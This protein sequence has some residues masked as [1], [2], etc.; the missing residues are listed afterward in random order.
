MRDFDCGY[1]KI[2]I[3]KEYKSHAMNA[4]LTNHLT[5]RKTKFLEDNSLELIISV[6]NKHKFENAFKENSVEATFQKPQGALS[7]I[8]RYKNRW[9]VLCGIILL[10]SSLIISSFFVWRIEVEGNELITD[11]EVIKILEESG[12]ALGTFIPNIDYDELH[13]R[14]LLNSKDV[15]WISVNITGNV[16]KVSIRERLKGNENASKNTYTNVISKYDAQIISVQLYKG[17]KVVSIG[18]VVRKGE[19]LISGVIDSQSQSVR[20]LHA[21]GIIKGYVNK[22]ILV[23]VPFK[24][25][26]KH[27]TGRVYEEKSV[28]IFSKII[29]FSIKGRNYSEFCDKIEQ[30]EAI[31]LFGVNLPLKINKTYYREYDFK[32]VNYTHSEAVDIAFKEL[33]AKLD[34]ELENS[35]IISKDVKTYYD[36]EFFYINCNLYCIEDISELVE[37]EVKN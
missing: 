14:F 23:K 32:D 12:F 37:F 31:K 8:S 18:D 3:P 20:Y 34:S 10:F 35:E 7:R 25:T 21:D 17:K 4:I 16:A 9:G 11:E 1:I 26:E 36:D 33:R 13:N 24:N 19:L 27:Y 28:E 15:S 22:Q 30:S 29:N 6:R 5:Y 2:I